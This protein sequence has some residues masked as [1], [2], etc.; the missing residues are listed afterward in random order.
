[1]VSPCFHL[2]IARRRAWERKADS[3]PF[4]FSA[5]TACD[6]GYELKG[7]HCVVKKCHPRDCYEDLPSHAYPVCTKNACS[8]GSSLSLP[9]PYPLPS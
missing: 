1:M 9:S 7:K 3:F 5:L 8:F 2:S 6:H 4:P